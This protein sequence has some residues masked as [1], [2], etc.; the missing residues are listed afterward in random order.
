MGSIKTF[1]D[2]NLDNSNATVQP[3]SFSEK[4]IFFQIAWNDSWFDTNSD[5]TTGD[6]IFRMDNAEVISIDRLTNIKLPY[7]SNNEGYVKT[8]WILCIRT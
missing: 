5:D 4:K 1:S 8:A 7:Y 3:Q 2:L 6:V